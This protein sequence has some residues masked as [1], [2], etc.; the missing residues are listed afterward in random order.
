MQRQ[1]A[2]DAAVR[3]HALDI[4]G[5]AARDEGQRQDLVGKRPRRAG[6]DALAAR[7]AR[8]LAHRVVEVKCDAG[9]VALAR[10]ADDFVA[11]NLIARADTAVA[12]DAGLVIDGDD[13]AGGVLWPGE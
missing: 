3:A 13:R 5:V 11:L 7:H 2:T 8:A 9:F 4:L 10:A 1:G 12:E 6:R